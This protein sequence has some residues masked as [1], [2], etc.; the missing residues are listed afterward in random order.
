MK[1]GL[2]ILMLA[3]MLLS[4]ENETS[5]EA[6]PEMGEFYT[7]SCGLKAVGTDSVKCF[8]V[9]VDNFVVKNPEAKQHSLYPKIVENIKAS[10][11]NFTFT[12]DTTD[13]AT[14]DFQF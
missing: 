5:Y 3:V 12:F 11:L 10:S 9:K 1:K 4:C 14:I 6:Y 8:A 13:G 7:E 2:T